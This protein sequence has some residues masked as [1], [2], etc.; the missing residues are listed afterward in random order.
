[1][2]LQLLWFAIVGVMFVAYF[3]LDGFDFGVG[4][5]MPLLSRDDVDRR[6]MINTIAPVW[7]LNET[8]L[9]IGGAALFAAFPEWYATMFS[10]FYVP[11][12]LILLALIVR[13]VSFEW[14]HQHDDTRWR[15]TWDA[16]IVAGSILPPLL[17]GVAF[18]N[19]AHG[20]AL[21]PHQGGA[22]MTDGLLGV[23]HPYAL[24]GG[25]ALV[26]LCLA[27]GVVFTALK[28]DGDLQQRAIR[29]ARIALPAA[30][31][32]GG[33]FLAWTIAIVPAPGV[34]AAA[35]VA[36]IALVVAL[37]A[38]LRAREGVA[39]AATAI[40]IAA[41][42]AT[43]LLALALRDGGPYV[44]PASNPVGDFV[45]LTIRN[46]SSSTYT[47]QVMSWTALAAMPL[48]AGY[49][50]WTYWVF[51]KRILRETIAAAAH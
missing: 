14:R 6:H 45:G 19:L 31:V 34:V 36:A 37:L 22:L 40:A 21:E 9:I 39:F 41:A 20:V 30:I 44:M 25:L 2:D 32:V 5:S 23:L 1:M 8:W 35:A 7:D 15:R 29:M 43:I 13:A 3:V 47:L 42:V 26:A 10:G 27:H 38:A 33:A 17:W 4:M 12:L 46:A 48:I 49:Q 18:A 11:L 51:R 50:L 28:T 24:L 16:C